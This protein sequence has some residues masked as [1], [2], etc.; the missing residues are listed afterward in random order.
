LY[1]TSRQ[2]VNSGTPETTYYVYD[3]S[4]QRVRKVTERQNGSRKEERIYVGGFEIYREYDT[5]SNATLERQTLHVMDDKQR[6]ALVEVR[7]EGN[8][9]T[10]TQL[11]R[12]QF[13]NHLGSANL[14]LDDGA[15]II[16]YEEYY[17]YGST[18]YQAVNQNMKVA[19][20]RY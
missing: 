20:K 18:S 19:A 13:S 6:V 2:A 7:T 15:K 3:A 8:D 17:P 10:P 4:G 5:T 16:S 9:G 1:G 14:E 11:I 12:F